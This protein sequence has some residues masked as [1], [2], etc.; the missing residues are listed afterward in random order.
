MLASPIDQDRLRDR[1]QNYLRSKTRDDFIIEKFNRGYCSGISSL[2]LYS[3]WLQT[4]PNPEHKPRDDYD[5]FKNTVNLICGWDG[6]RSLTKEE[7][8]EFERFI[9]HIE[10]FQHITDHATSAAQVHGEIAESLQDTKGRVLKKEYSIGSLFTLEQLENLLATKGIIQDGKL[11]LITANGHATALFRKKDKYFYFNS[12]SRVGEVE[13]IS[14]DQVA[15]LIFQAHSLGKD[16][17]S[18]PV[19]F[20]MFTFGEVN[21]YPKEEGVLK[22]IG[23]TADEKTSAKLLAT[24][25]HAAAYVGS[26][27]SVVTLLAA[28]SNPNIRDDRGLTALKYAVEK[29]NIEIVELLNKNVNMQDSSGVTNLISAVM[30][31]NT[32]KVIELLKQPGI[33]VNLEDNRGRTALMH[34]VLGGP[35]EIVKELLKQRGVDVNLKGSYDYTALMYAVIGGRPEILKGFLNQ[36]GIDVNLKDNYDIT[37]LMHAVKGGHPEIVKE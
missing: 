18:L 5:W 7:S 9:S 21:E 10:Y 19:G 12:N 27:G 11:I 2:W 6:K 32:E 26:I 16:F 25:L 30:Q 17:S 29:G 24:G 36:P 23:A 28:G 8:E 1:I 34:A 20:R 14:T 33:D 4:Q 13:A 22:G 3:T 37:A 15:E 35:P 31:G